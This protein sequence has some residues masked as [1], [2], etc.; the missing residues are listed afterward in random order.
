MNHF[1]IVF[2]SC[3]NNGS[4]FSITHSLPL[5][6]PEL[7]CL[8]LAKKGLCL[9]YLGQILLM[10]GLLPQLQ[11][12]QVENIVVLRSPAQYFKVKTLIHT[13][14]SEHMGVSPSTGKKLTRHSFSNILAHTHHTQHAISPNDFSITSST[15]S[16]S[17]LELVI[18]ESLLI[19]KFKP[20]INESISLIPVSLFQLCMH[21]RLFQFNVTLQFCLF[22]VIGLSA[23]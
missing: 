2:A 9:L 13:Q 20:S 18:W 12:F 1:L 17:N 19:S 10:K 5:S 23:N 15:C 6:L 7:K 8:S 21:N 3:N 22:I 14:I 11:I 4:P 16:G